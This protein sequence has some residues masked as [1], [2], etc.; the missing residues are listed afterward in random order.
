MKDKDLIKKRIFQEEDYIY[1]PRLSNSVEKLFKKNQF[2]IDD[3]RICKVLLITPVELKK[4]YASAIEK[5]R[6]KLNLG[7]ND[8]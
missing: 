3:E 5:L 4:F 7:E 2:G 6:K 8:E 1:C